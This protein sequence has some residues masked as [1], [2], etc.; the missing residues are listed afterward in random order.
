MGGNIGFEYVGGAASAARAGQWCEGL[1]I[2]AASAP[3]AR[4]REEEQEEDLH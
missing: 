1:A 3:A 2:L 4:G